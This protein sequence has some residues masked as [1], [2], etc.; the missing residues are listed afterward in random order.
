MEHPDFTATNF[1]ET[2]IDLKGLYYA[3]TYDKGAKSFYK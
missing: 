1:M 3:S 2:S